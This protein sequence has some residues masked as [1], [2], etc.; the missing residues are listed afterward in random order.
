[1]SALRKCAA[2]KYIWKE[3][4]WYKRWCSP[5]LWDNYCIET[6][7]LT[8]HM[9]NKPCVG[10]VYS[11]SYKWMC[12]S[13]VITQLWMCGSKWQKGHSHLKQCNCLIYLLDILC[14][15]KISKMW[16]WSHKH[17]FTLNDGVGVGWGRGGGICQINF[18]LIIFCN[19]TPCGN[20]AKTVFSLPCDEQWGSCR[21]WLAMYVV[22]Y[23]CP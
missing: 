19:Y 3:N 22:L 4:Y 13:C 8:K 11:W 14:E 23:K 16:H 10:R 15:Y 5:V 17:T 7:W 20:K 6:C 21:H 18:C 9:K 12:L 2:L 1:M